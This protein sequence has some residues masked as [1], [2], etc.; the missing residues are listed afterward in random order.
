MPFLTLLRRRWG[1]LISRTMPHIWELLVL[2]VVVLTIW[3]CGG[4]MLFGRS[5]TVDYYSEDQLQNFKNFPQAFIAMYVLFTT[6]NYPDI[7]EPA[8][9]QNKLYAFFFCTFLMLVMFFLGNLAIPTLYRAFKT[10]HHREALHGRILERTALLAAFQLLDIEKK[11]YIGADTFKDVL[12][13]IRPDMFNENGDEKERGMAKTMFIELSQTDPDRKKLYPIDFFR[14]CEVILVDWRVS[15]LDSGKSLYDRVCGGELKHFRLKLQIVLES[16]LFD[17]LVLGLCT[18]VTFFTAFYNSGVVSNDLISTVG[19]IYVYMCLAEQLLKLYVIGFKELWMKWPS[20][21]DLVIITWSCLAQIGGLFA[22]DFTALVGKNDLS[23]FL[24]MYR[25]S[26]GSLF[27]I[28][29]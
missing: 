7:M 26:M 22:D 17:K 11:G 19:E 15:R 27:I 14:C 20:K 16:L 4:V 10:N 5:E 12:G 1:M 18:L 6:E 21:Y 23:K 3:S 13:R 24:L 8:Y 25:G 28:C 2:L 29:R 9:K